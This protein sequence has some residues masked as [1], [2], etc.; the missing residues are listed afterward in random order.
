VIHT[1]THATE[2]VVEPQDG[3]LDH[4]GPLSARGFMLTSHGRGQFPVN[5]RLT[6]HS[7]VYNFMA[8]DS[9]QAQLYAFPSS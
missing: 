7:L 8:M 6:A 1:S 5:D 2:G 4:R 3:V 9:S